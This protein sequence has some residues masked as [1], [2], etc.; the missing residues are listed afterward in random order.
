MKISLDPTLGLSDA[1]DMR[2]KRFSSEDSL[3]A[4]ASAAGYSINCYRGA[5]GITFAGQN[6]TKSAFAYA[7]G[8][9][10]Y[11]HITD[12]NTVELVARKFAAILKT[13]LSAGEQ[14]LVIER[15]KG[16]IGTPYEG[17]CASGDFCDSNMA[18]DEAFQSFG[19]E[20]DIQDDAQT[21]LWNAAWDMAKANDFWW[22]NS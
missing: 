21:A 18:M 12:K 8:G 4:Y 10:W 5:N 3:L 17:C 22:F 9:A 15:N 19:V 7:S 2:L 20:I 1:L 13:W 11:F 14:K 16:Y 6:G